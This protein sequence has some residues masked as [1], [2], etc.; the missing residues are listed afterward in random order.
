MRKNPGQYG[1]GKRRRRAHPAR[2]WKYMVGSQTNYSSYR[3]ISTM[4]TI[5]LK[6][7]YQANRWFTWRKDA[8]K[9]CSSIVPLYHNLLHHHHH[10]YLKPRWN[11]RTRFWNITSNTRKLMK[12]RG[13]RPSAFIVFECLKPRL[14]TKHEFLKLL[15][16][17]KK[18]SLNNHLNKFSQFNYYIWDVKYAWTSKKCVWCAWS[19]HLIAA[20]WQLWNI[21]QLRSRYLA[22]C[23]FRANTLL[24]NANGSVQI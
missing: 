12:A 24:R 20:L 18:I 13:R 10:I 15:F 16:Q 2:Q 21:L 6:N 5:H 11:T 19:Y 3:N 22:V 7:H 14:N 1:E 9:Y 8:R 4:E 17:Q 23:E